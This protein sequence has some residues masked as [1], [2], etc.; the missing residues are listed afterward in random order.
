M[1]RLHFVFAQRRFYYAPHTTTQV[2][3]SKC[4]DNTYDPFFSGG[5]PAFDDFGGSDGLTHLHATRFLLTVVEGSAIFDF[6]TSVL[7][8]FVTQKISALLPS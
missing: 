1:I 4:V 6:Q 3:G 5:K 7:M 2:W 8:P